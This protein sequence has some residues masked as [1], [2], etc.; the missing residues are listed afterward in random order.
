MRRD[1]QKLHKQ[2]D[3]VETVFL[4]N[5][6]EQ[7]REL[8][9]E[10]AEK[11]ERLDQ[12]EGQ[13]VSAKKSQNQQHVAF[14][15]GLC[16]KLESRLESIKSALQPIRERFGLEPELLAKQQELRAKAEEVEAALRSA[17]SNE[18][19][20][21]DADFQELRKEVQRADQE[22]VA[23]LEREIE[24][25][26]LEKL[27][28]SEEGNAAKES[29]ETLLIRE[30]SPLATKIWEKRALKT[31]LGKITSQLETAQRKKA[32]LNDAVSTK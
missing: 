32:E 26:A 9:C 13:R 23:A 10:R 27:K 6:S 17:E 2:A 8:L 15:E 7:A 29:I 3:D 30:K 4:S 5:K 11:R 1:V 24:R 21:T 18:P 20:P 14:Y 28:L 12:Y 31:E 22:E 25:L 16:Q 19:C